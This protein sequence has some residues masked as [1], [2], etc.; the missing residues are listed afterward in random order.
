MGKSFAAGL[1]P[2][3]LTS[4][5]YLVS[6]QAVEFLRQNAAFEVSLAMGADRQELQRK[7]AYLHAIWDRLSESDQ[8]ACSIHRPRRVIDQP[9]GAGGG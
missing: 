6:P 1:P 3:R 9:M 5:I 2:R 4:R 7:E 8:Q